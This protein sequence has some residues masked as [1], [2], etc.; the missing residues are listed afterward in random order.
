MAARS[1]QPGPAEVRPCAGAAQP[2][3]PGLVEAPL[4][5]GAARSN[6]PVLAQLEVAGPQA[7]T[8]GEVAGVGTHRHRPSEAQVDRDWCLAQG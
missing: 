2:S 4:Q 5:A 7:T 1:N 3:W 6:Q 8:L